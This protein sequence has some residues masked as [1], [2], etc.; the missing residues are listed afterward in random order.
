M[1]KKRQK[2]ISFVLIIFV[3][4]SGVCFESIKTDS[5]YLYVFTEK[6]DSCIMSCEEGI[7]NTEYCQ[8]EMLGSCDSARLQ[9]INNQCV[10]QKREIRVSLDFLYSN[11]APLFQ[12]KS[13][14]D[15]EKI[16]FW[17]QYPKEFVLNYI[18]KSD[19]NKRI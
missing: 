6:A 7:L 3:F 19:G 10:N 18:H 12:G 15:S 1:Q 16:Y 13:V 2:F 14:S 8:A 4:L 11:I 5:F 9:K 17:N